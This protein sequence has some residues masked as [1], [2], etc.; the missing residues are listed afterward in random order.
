MPLKVIN[1][2]ALNK[3]LFLCFLAMISS[4]IFY[5]GILGDSDHAYVYQQVLN[6]ST[7]SGGYIEFILNADFKSLHLSSWILHDYILFNVSTFALNLIGINNQFY[8][9]YFIGW[10]LSF[11]FFLALAEFYK[12]IRKN[13]LSNSF[14]FFATCA[15]FFSTSIIC[16]STGYVSESI[17][18]F[19]FV[20]RMKYSN[21]TYRV[22]LDLLIISIKPYYAVISIF[23][24]ISESKKIQTV[25][26]FNLSSYIFK[27]RSTELI[28]ILLILL[29]FGV[30]KLPPILHDNFQFYSRGFDLYFAFRNLF[31]I[32][33][34]PSFGSIFT[35]LAFFIFIFR[36]W[37]GNKTL[38]KII[39]VI[40]LSFF[41][42]FLPYWHGQ[43]GGSRYLAPVFIIFLPEIIKTL[44]IFEVNMKLF[45]R[46]VTVLISLLIILNLSVIEYRNTTIKEYLSGTVTENKTYMQRFGYNDAD[47][48]FYDYYDINFHPS[49]FGFSIFFSKFLNHEK[50]SLGKVIN[51]V[52]TQNFYPQSGF[53]RIMFIEKYNLHDSY[54]YPIK[55]NSIHLLFIRGLY[56][57]FFINVLCLVIINTVKIV[58]NKK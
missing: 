25:N 8:F 28:S 27:F 52:P 56:Y 13:G 36:G 30:T 55:L 17:I 43:M 51:Q 19:L 35:L 10:V 45:D 49:I 4:F 39:S 20:L 3:N 11:Y 15:V 38:I 53:G 23:L 9:E 42:S 46:S 29:F 58:V 22:V 26:I 6:I 12:I 57:L 14:A 21:S 37:N 24:Y 5:E 48:D 1:T 41:L 16:F 33:F 40:I 18:L 54:P 50:I 47:Q 31:L 44:K 32:F 2:I 34:S 7:M